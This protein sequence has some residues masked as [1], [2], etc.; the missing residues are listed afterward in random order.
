MSLKYICL[1][2]GGNDRKS[3]KVTFDS[4]IREVKEKNINN[5]QLLSEFIKLINVMY[6]YNVILN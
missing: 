5:K 1:K 6:K 2:I 3:I 4:F